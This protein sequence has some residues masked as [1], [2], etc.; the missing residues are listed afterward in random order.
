[1]SEFERNNEDCINLVR[2]HRDCF[3]RGERVVLA[4]EEQCRKL[5]EERNEALRESKNS[6]IKIDAARAE[7]RT[8]QV[9]TLAAGVIGI[10]AGFITGILV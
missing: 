7:T 8:W 5:I 1:M 6:T 3:P 10:I 4:S 2:N 9:F